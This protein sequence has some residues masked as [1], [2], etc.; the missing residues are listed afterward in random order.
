MVEKKTILIVDDDIVSLNA[1]RK[2]LEP[3][4]EISLAKSASMA[5]NILNSTLIDLVLLDVE[6]PT[7]SGLDFINYLRN[8]AAF[9]HIPV[10]FLTSH[11]TEDI[12]KKAMYSG[13]DGFV[14]K[15]VTHAILRGKIQDAFDNTK[16]VTERGI[17]LQKLHTLDIFCKNGKSAD[18][19]KLAEELKKVRYNVGTD[20]MLK[21]IHKEVI[22]LNYSFATEKIDEL[23]K[24]KLFEVNRRV[25]D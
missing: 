15:P 3:L 13:A 1:A 22:Q 8:N 24:N 9:H 10:I 18:A 21:I 5:W 17:L 20:K 12:L 6:M 23:I 2:I 11:G 16:P 4:Y 25:D 19:E 14:V 7:L